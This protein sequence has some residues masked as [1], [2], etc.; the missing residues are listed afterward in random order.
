VTCN[1]KTVCAAVVRVEA[2]GHA[3]IIGRHSARGGSGAID[4]RLFALLA[5]A[6]LAKSGVAVERNSK[7]GSRVLSRAAK[8]S[9]MALWERFMVYGFM[10]QRISASRSSAAAAAALGGGDAFGRCR[11]VQA[12]HILST[13]P[14]T[15]VTV[16]NVKDDTDLNVDLSRSD[17]E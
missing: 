10:A 14:E 3:S 9:F 12:K 6:V 16:E 4:Q 1:P 7:L 5:A 15:R 13:V 11:I 2:T 8:V 17:L